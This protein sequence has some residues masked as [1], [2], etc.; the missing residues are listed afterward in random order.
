[1]G[2]TD[3]IELQ[4]HGALLVSGRVLVENTLRHSLIDL[5]HRNLV[6]AIGI[7]AIAL[8]RGGLELFDR[9]LEIGLRGLVAGVPRLPDED[10][11][12]RTDLYSNRE[13]SKK[14][15]FFFIFS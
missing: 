9:G 7:G 3:P 10:K 11:S 1:M 12:Y 2:S 8:R 5:F 13:S 15:G 4:G 14:Q 6:S